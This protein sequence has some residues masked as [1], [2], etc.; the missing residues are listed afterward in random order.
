MTLDQDIDLLSRVALFEGFSLDQLRLLAFGGEKRRLPEGGV[1][2]RR[3]QRA[4]GGYVVETGM[5][6]LLIVKGQSEQFLGG[7]GPASLIGELA[8]ISDTQ[9]AT[10]ALARTETVAIGIPRTLFM[11]MLAEY[12]RTA[13]LL[14]ERIAASVHKTVSG[15]SQ[16]SEGLSRQPGFAAIDGRRGD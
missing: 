13:M 3:N 7:F 8:L 16:V 2:Y 1:L 9:R 5:I 6:D 11:R 12:P 4:D 14:H 15:L 10:A